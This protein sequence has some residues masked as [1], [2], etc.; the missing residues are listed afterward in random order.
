MPSSCRTV[1]RGR[2]LLAVVFL[3]AGILGA[4]APVV[5][6]APADHLILSEIV[7]TANRFGAIYVEIVNP[8][9]SGV[10]LDQVA[11]TNGT[12]TGNDTGYWRIAEA[13]P[14]A[15][16]AGGGS[17]GTFHGLFPAGY[18]LAAGDTIV[19]AV[20]GSDDYED[21]YGALPDF[22]V[23]EDGAVPDGVPELVEVFPGSIAAGLGGGANAP[24]LSGVAGS[25]MLYQWDPAGDLV[26]DLDYFHWGTNDAFRVDKTGVTVGTGSYLPDTGAAAQQARRVTDSAGDD[27]SFGRTGDDEGTEVTPGNGATGHDETSEML[28]DNWEVDAQSPPAPPA[29]HH[30]PAAIVTAT[31]LVP[32]APAEDQDVTVSVTVATPGS[33]TSMVLHYAVDGGGEVAVSGDDAGGGTWSAG[34][35]EQLEGAVVTWWAEVTNSDGQTTVYP[36]AAPRFTDSWTTDAPFVPGDGPDKLLLTEVCTLGVDQEFVEIHNPNA[37]DVD[38]SNYYL[39]DAVYNDQGYWRMGDGN[40]GQGTIGGG[41]FYDFQARFPDGFS[42]AAGDTIVVS[43]PGSAA[44]SGTF[45]FLPD[46]ELFED[47]VISDTVADMRW[48]FGD[49]GNNS[50][51]GAT[52]PSLTNTG[53]PIVLYYYEPAAA[54]TVDIDMFI[55]GT[56]N[57]YQVD[58]TGVSVAGSTYLP[59]TAKGNQHPFGPALEFGDAYRRVAGEDGNQVPSGSNGVNGRDETS[60]NWLTTFAMETSDPSRPSGGGS[61]GEGAVELKVP[62]ATFLPV[63]GEIFPI[64]IVGKPNSETKVRI[65]DLEGR[66]IITLFDSRFDGNPST[67]PGAYTFVTW[68]GRDDRFEMMRAGMYI[69]HLSVVNLQTGDEDTQTAPVVL[70]TRLS[71]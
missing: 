61:A 42:I 38:M 9:G 31:G 49:A 45:G 58:K 40:L 24:T 8:L 30:A 11:L 36:S 15:L 23:Y 10:L 68:D 13:A 70:A 28:V 55:W 16:T 21:A 19:V 69:V 6:A 63:L 37:W 26:E 47:D 5:P 2:R 66:P 65:F 35:P 14:T 18:T 53:E 3:A 51:V 33:I 22:E 17:G 60:E 48:V 62:A 39:T 4:A 27:F 56:S 44:F 57:S 41:D 71:K 32:A 67:I 46:V 34:V 1:T 54:L 29:N 20:T 52:V 59:D 7:V 50:I 64:G 43:I 12:N 25:V